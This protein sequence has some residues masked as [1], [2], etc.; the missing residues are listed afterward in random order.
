L[1]YNEM[2]PP[3]QGNTP[4]ASATPRQV[5]PQP[6]Q[7]PGQHGQSDK[8]AAST[9]TA[10][11]GARPPP[12]APL[13]VP[14]QPKPSA[15]LGIFPLAAEPSPTTW[16]NM[17][18]AVAPGQGWTTDGRVPLHDGTYPSGSADDA[19]AQ[20]AK[21]AARRKARGSYAC[22]KCGQPKKGHVCSL[23]GGG[24]EDGNN[25]EDGTGDDDGLD[26]LLG[27]EALLENDPWASSGTGDGFGVFEGDALF[28][29][30]L[31]LALGDAA[32]TVGGNSEASGGHGGQAGK[33]NSAKKPL[34]TAGGYRCSRCGLPKKGH[35]C[36]FGDD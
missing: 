25:N 7:P 5:Q 26:M 3:G 13:A 31:A 32:L 6:P 35:V 10:S 22:S 24:G 30:A 11:K 36:A 29:D 34:R 19:A 33:P 1:D 9:T 23:G 2:V 27:S 4:R 21:D 12:L 15:S 20:A 18:G 8:S 28:D 17:A 14:P 16:D